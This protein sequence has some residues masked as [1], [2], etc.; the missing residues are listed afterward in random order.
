M[1]STELERSE[2]TYSSDTA[3][4]IPMAWRLTWSQR[5]PVTSQ[6]GKGCVSRQLE[7]PLKGPLMLVRYARAFVFLAEIFLSGPLSFL[8]TGRVEGT[9]MLAQPACIARCIW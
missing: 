8:S 7:Q 9:C 5:D 4:A 3:L 6:V 1:S 2:I